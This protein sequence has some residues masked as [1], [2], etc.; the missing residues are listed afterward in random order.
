MLRDGENLSMKR[1]NDYRP[2][3]DCALDFGNMEM[4][5]FLSP[6]KLENKRKQ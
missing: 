5:Y 2:V 4:K 1:G 3:G 6:D